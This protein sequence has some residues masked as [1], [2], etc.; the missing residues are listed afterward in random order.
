[1]SILTE[2][3]YARGNP[4][5]DADEQPAVQDAPSP[6]RSRGIRESAANDADRL[7]Y[8]SRGHPV[9][10]RTVIDDGITL[11]AAN[12]RQ[13]RPQRRRLGSVS[14]LGIDAVETAIYQEYPDP[15]DIDR[16]RDGDTVRQGRAS[17]QH[18][19]R[20][21]ERPRSR[22]YSYRERSRS[23]GYS[24]R[25]R[26]RSRDRRPK[27]RTKSRTRKHSRSRSRDKRERSRSRKMQYRD[28]KSSSGS[29][30]SSSE[31][32]SSSSWSMS[33]GQRLK[34]R[35]EKRREAPPDAV[36]EELAV[37]VDMWSEQM[38]STFDK[39][40]KTR[41]LRSKS[42]PLTEIPPVKTA[43][44][45]REQEP[46]KYVPGA[47]IDPDGRTENGVVGDDQDE[48]VEV[49]ERLSTMID[50]QQDIDYAAIMDAA[51]KELRKPRSQ[52]ETES[53][54]TRRQKAVARWG[55]IEPPIRE[56]V[57]AEAS[58]SRP[59]PRLTTKDRVVLQH[60]HN[61]DVKAQ[62]WSLYKDQGL[63]LDESGRKILEERGQKPVKKEPVDHGFRGHNNRVERT[64]ERERGREP[65]SE[66]SESSSDS[67]SSDHRS[68]R[69]NSRR[70]RERSRRRDRERDRDRD[71]RHRHRRHHSRAQRALSPVDDWAYVPNQRNHHLS[72]YL[73]DIHRKYHLM[74]EQ[75]VENPHNADLVN[76]RGGR[77]KL[78]TPD[79]YG[80]ESNIETFDIWLQMILRW[81]KLSGYAGEDVDDARVS[82]VAMFLTG[83]AHVWFNDN[84]ESVTRRIRRW[85]FKDV[86]TGLY[87][88]FI[89]DASIQDATTKFY[90]VTYNPATGVM[91]YYHDL[92]RYALRMIHPPDSYTFK[93]QL[94]MGLPAAIES[95]VLDIGV[96]AETSTTTTIV[97][98]A[99][100]FEESHRVHKMYEARRKAKK[101]AGNIP[102]VPK[103]RPRSPVMEQRP[104]PPMGQMERRGF[105]RNRPVRP[106]E[107]RGGNRPPER[108]SGPRPPEQPKARN[109]AGKQPERPPR[110]DGGGKSADVTCFACGKRGHYASDPVC[111]NK[112]K[113]RVAAIQEEQ[114]AAAEAGPSANAE[115]AEAA[116]GTD[117][118]YLDV[119]D[120]E[121][122]EDEQYYGS[123]YT[124][125]NDVEQYEEY[126][127]YSDP[128]NSEML[129]SIRPIADDANGDTAIRASLIAMNEKPS[130]K[131]KQPAKLRMRV[132]KEPRE[133]PHKEGAMIQPI[134][135]KMSLNGLEAVVMFDTG[136]TAD[137][138]SPE[139]ARVSDTKVSPLT[140]SVP[141]Q[142]GCKGSRA[143]IT[144]G[145]ECTVKY[146]PV[147]GPHYF[148][149]VNIDRFDAI[150]GI[151][152]MRK[153]GI[154][155]DPLANSIIIRGQAFPAFSE[156]EERTEI[157]RRTAVRRTGTRKPE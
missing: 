153:H 89:H 51:E 128:E 38:Q 133:R 10:Q 97:N 78:P 94:M 83:K 150:I 45:S 43:D 67:D 136:S 60:L 75:Q 104:R 39:W 34:R 119:E 11:D 20:Q 6:V 1:M 59:K 124:S 118:H 138:I 87:D 105:P 108:R 98:K 41:K 19:S 144:H 134:V 147:N 58:G 50:T 24:R 85:S 63:I 31:S 74:I 12:G 52:N 48:P 80:G 143:N 9:H 116:A 157:A 26:S 145:T 5:Q 15:R 103:P 4:A 152:F 156:G 107:R 131:D 151:G 141:V 135:T 132:S 146:G 57:N 68:R 69:H 32:S 106:Q 70:R 28:Q 155:L 25:E 149:I 71:D 33:E 84:V 122:Q 92:E 22:A 55:K 18:S 154:V 125:E 130:G 62:G 127:E 88:R 79:Q 139:F 47:Y 23:H 109:D 21:R 73:R 120:E 65:P 17:G 148:D 77:A 102:A 14:E 81:M 86:V 40:R 90:E 61:S 76:A 35:A 100:Q 13:G 66:P 137:A 111:P 16:G 29:S 123:Q 46:G 126:Y 30:S 114:E 7:S 8:T 93:T 115:A 54:Y 121:P 110:K 3:R 36:E 129:Y 27:R 101:P 113:P 95:A 37:I 99:R 2:L 44:N 49:N 82:I 42:K 112:G 64:R 56:E 72:R 142:L 53:Q 96:S 140:V 91:G 117:V